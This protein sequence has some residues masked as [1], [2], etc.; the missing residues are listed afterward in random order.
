M[1][2]R[3]RWL[4]SA[5]WLGMRLIVPSPPCRRFEASY[6]DQGPHC[7]PLD[8]A[9]LSL[10]RGRQGPLRGLIGDMVYFHNTVPDTGS[11]LELA[12]FIQGDRTHE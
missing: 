10:F 11:M 1:M 3:A 5:S 8:P 4:D 9:S 6:L 2:D 7:R 12:T